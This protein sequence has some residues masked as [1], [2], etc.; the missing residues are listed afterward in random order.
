MIVV[1]QR[2]GFVVMDI[3]VLIIGHT[4]CTIVIDDLGQ[5]RVLLILSKT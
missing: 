2:Q 5:G 4:L 3:T 1:E